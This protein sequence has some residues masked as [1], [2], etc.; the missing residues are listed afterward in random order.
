MNIDSDRLN[1]QFFFVLRTCKVEGR[2]WDF[3]A[4]QTD[5]VGACGGLC[6][7]PN[8]AIKMCK[9]TSRLNVCGLHFT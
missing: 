3:G 6:S 4:R 5:V 2:V 8:L 1:A 9:Y 7:K